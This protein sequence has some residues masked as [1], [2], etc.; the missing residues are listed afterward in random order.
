MHFLVFSGKSRLRARNGA[1]A[2]SGASA[3]P[4]SAERGWA[5][6]RVEGCWLRV[7]GRNRAG[8][9]AGPRSENIS[10]IF[11]MFGSAG[12]GPSGRPLAVWGRWF[13]HLSL[14]YIQSQKAE[15]SIGREVLSKRDCNRY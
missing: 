12:E 1:G 2:E 14:I 15:F 3:R 9:G 6:L 4:C 10:F 7:E 5:A 11:F 13:I 8:S